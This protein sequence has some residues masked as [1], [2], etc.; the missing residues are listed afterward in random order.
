MR[1]LHAYVF[2]SVLTVAA[3]AATAATGSISPFTPKVLPVLVQ[4]NAEGKVTGISPAVALPPTFNHLLAE[5]LNQLI[6]KPAYDHGKPVSSQF[7]INLELQATP[8]DEGD[9][10]AHFAYVSTSPLPIGTWHWVNVEG[11][12]IALANQDWPGSTH[13]AQFVPPIMHGFNAGISAP[14]A[15]PHAGVASGGRSG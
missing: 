9:Y 13:A 4:V 5:N 1:R 15:A 8:R 3:G 14:V 10:D 7:V 6:T 2:A 11:Q 12:R